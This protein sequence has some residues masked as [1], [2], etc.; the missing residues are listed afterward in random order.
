MREQY[1]C[2]YKGL[3]LLGLHFV[4]VPS[5]LLGIGVL[6]WFR[7]FSIPGAAECY[8]RPHSHSLSQ[9]QLLDGLPTWTEENIVDLD[10]YIAR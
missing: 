1:T 7:R 8:N 5:T 6:C 3:T 9:A 10:E 4:R 2:L